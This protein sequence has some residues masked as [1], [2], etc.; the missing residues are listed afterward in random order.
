M[1]K[2]DV[3]FSKLYK[4]C[5]EN[6]SFLGDPLPAFKNIP[7][8]CS[9]DPNRV[10]R[11]VQFKDKTVLFEAKGAV[12][13]DGSPVSCGS[14][15]SK[16]DQCETW[17][18]YDKDSSTKYV[19][20]EEVPF[21]VIPSG[22]PLKDKQDPQSN[23]SFMRATGIGKG[24]LAVAF[25]DGNCSYGVVGDAG[26]YFRLGELSIAAHEDLKNPQ[27]KGTEKP[28]TKLIGGGSGSGFASGVTYIV[29]PGTRPKPLTSDNVVK[30][31][32]EKSKASLE[33]FLVRNVK[34]ST[35]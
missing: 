6:N 23:V 24:D 8:K 29:F 3:S 14:N 7:M 34:A 17:L 2:K 32:A 15:K 26:P 35:P 10:G 25:H 4:E 12:D 1:A 11:I 19:N 9:T 21:V 22:S 33:S 31:S 5:D 16:T 18:T 30:I 27:C 13:A 28:C 20:A